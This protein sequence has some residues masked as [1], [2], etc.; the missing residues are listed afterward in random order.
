MTPERWLEVRLRNPGADAELLVEALLDA[1]GRAVWEEDGWQVTHLPDPGTPQELDRVVAG[2]RGALP[3]G[4]AL[5]LETRWQRQEDW[6]EF[7]KRGLDARRVT[8]RIVVTPTWIEPDTRPGDLVIS[9]DPK[10][11]FGNAEHGTTRGCLRILDRAVRPGDR[12]L[13]VGAGSAILSIA[14][15]LLGA[16]SVDALEVDPLAIPAARENLEANGVADTVTLGLR[17]VT[18]ADLRGME[19]Y[20][21]VMANLETGF[22]RP[23]LPGLAVAARPGGWVLLSGILAHEWEEVRGLAESLGLHFREV[24]ADG[25]WRSGLFLRP[26]PPGRA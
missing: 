23:L 9:L 6:A 1:G 13:D 3:G 11:A 8:P 15:A 12:L 21:G 16:G 20:D 5:E 19:P 14:G 22:L 17:R 26:Q 18:A 2:L 7:W 25:E 10:M 24:D 4:D